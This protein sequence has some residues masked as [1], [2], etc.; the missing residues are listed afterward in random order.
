MILRTLKQ[1]KK[2][3]AMANGNLVPKAN[4][5]AVAAATDRGKLSK[6]ARGM[7]QPKPTRPYESTGLP[8]VAHCNALAVTQIPQFLAP[9]GR[10]RG[11]KTLTAAN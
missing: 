5:L 7:S 6:S 3:G 1:V 2:R 8:G 10:C 9:H 11:I 4:L